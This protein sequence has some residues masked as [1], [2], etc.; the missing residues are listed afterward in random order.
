MA[1]IVQQLYAAGVD[2]I[3]NGHDHIYERFAP[4]NASGQADPSAGIREFIVGTGGANHTSIASIARNSEVRNANTFGVL[5]LTLHAR[6]YDW[7]FQPA[8]F[9]GNGSFTD[10]GTGSCH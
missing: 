7:D 8:S 9:A 2:V 1:A 6:G 5:K 4:Q 10:S 3:L